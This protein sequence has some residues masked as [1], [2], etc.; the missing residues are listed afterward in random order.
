MALLSLLGLHMNA[1]VGFKHS[2]LDVFRVALFAGLVVCLTSLSA[3]D[4][5]AQES[6][7]AP[8]N[9]T[10]QT[11]N[12]P[13]SNGQLEDDALF[14][15][16]RNQWF[17]RQRAYPYAHI[18]RGAYWHAQ[19]QRLVLLDRRARA[20]S[21]MRP[22]IAAQA[23]PFAGVTWTADG[24]DPVYPSSAYAQP[25]SGRATSVAVVPT[26]AN[27]IYLGTAAGGVWKTTDGG[28]TWTPLT[29]SQASLAI[30]AVAV[31]PNNPSTVFAGTGEPDFSADSYYGQGLL[32]STDAGATWTMIRAPF[33]TGDTAPNFASIAV[34]PGNSNVVLAGNVGWNGGLF[35]SA[36]GGQTWTQVIAAG[37]YAGAT[38]VLFDVKNP[39]TVYA[40]VGG[41]SS[42]ASATVLISTDSGLTWKPIAGSGTTG[43]PAPG[44]V[45]RTALAETSDGKTLFAAFANSNFTSPG[46][47]YS[48]S[49]SGANWTQL[50]S[51][52]G[53]SWYCNA[54][55]VTP[56]NPQVLYAT[57]A[58]LYESTDG[59]KTWAPDSSGAFY[60]DE[61]GFAFSGDGS[62]MF[63]ADDGGI[64]ATSQPTVANAVFVSLNQTLNTLTFY[65]GFSLLAGQSNSLLAGS[66]DHGLN[67]YTGSS[68]A[69]ASGD[70]FRFCGDGTGVYIDPK[71][72]YAY[73]HCEGG[74]AAWISNASGDTVAS[75]WNAA[76][77]GISTSDRW[78]WVADIKGDW[79]TVSTVYTGTNRL[80]QSTNN[81]AAWTA[82]S[83][84]LTGG[85][86]TISTI[87]VAPT[88]SNTI[89]T[90]AGDGTVS[91]TANALSG[92][93][94]VWKTL[95][96]LPARAISKIIVMPDSAQDVYL[97][98]SG[99]GAGHVFHSTNGGTT[100]ADISGN[101]PNTPVDSIAADPSLLNTLYL[102]TDTGVYVTSNG[103]STWE[104]LGTGLPNVVVMDL[105][106]DAANR[107]LR[108]ITHGRGAWDAALPLAALESSAVSVSFGSQTRGTKSAAQTITLTNELS[109]GA[110][111]LNSPQITGPFTQTNSCGTSLSPGAA[112]TVNVVFA[113]TAAG[114]AQGTLTVAT[115]D[116]S[117][118]VLLAG[119]GLG[120]PNA[121]L[122]SPALTFGNQPA[123]IASARQTVQL[124]NTGDAALANL[125]VTVAG[126]NRG[127]FSQTNNCGTSV[128]A[129]GSC[130]VDIVFTPGGTGSRSASLS[131][132][133]NAAGSPQ[134]VTLGGTGTPPFALAA[135]SASATVS[136]GASAT[137]NLTVTAAQGA[138]L[139][140]VVALSCSGAPS[141]ATCGFNPV[142]VATGA[143]TQ[144]VT[145]TVTTA[146]ASVPVHAYLT[147]TRVISLATLSLAGLLLPRRRARLWMV[148][149]LA[150]LCVGIPGCSGGGGGGGSHSPGTPAG[151]YNITVTAAQSMYQTTQTVTLTVQ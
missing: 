121:V 32:K 9:L 24:P 90:G 11:E 115:T 124:S 45:L 46:T 109:T 82:I 105:L 93:S 118:T 83:G 28:Q 79:A 29:D 26:D 70:G 111:T 27:T 33:T 66:Q 25:P 108:V 75:N 86:S 106:I 110:L 113:P 60:A 35:R 10:P 143:T 63:V 39:A 126:T 131:I 100:W 71:G 138:P 5:R 20:L 40:G 1:T 87:A 99:F 98:Q 64:Y 146:P 38:A 117:V 76:Q 6:T 42:T 37:G 31:D 58:T 59:G 81:G 151:T 77:T 85:S 148:A 137:Y 123:G 16:K 128:A 102:A 139:A 84:D 3:P 72:T 136:A 36:D 132:A 97:T 91:V 78:P 101:L 48:T 44:A 14:P 135:A 130:T 67:L 15:M 74:A 4:L 114:A 141:L 57:G 2:C 127:D 95:S 17:L 107:K 144:N 13:E 8:E 22:E 21:A 12:V 47:L 149:L 104:P 116:N 18:P 69:W 142:A 19:T 7:R 112:C 94:A 119:T 120:I 55:A 34:Q 51:P 62:R 88:D 133:D 103:G 96:G 129:G 43:I 56:G 30:G 50:T 80:Y 65:P 122:G 49:N 145:L 68:T 140:S 92:T 150:I 125:V 89:Y 53:L 73:A 147:G 41:L 61:H 23:D 54:I 134:T 52:G